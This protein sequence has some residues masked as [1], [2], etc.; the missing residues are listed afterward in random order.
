MKLCVAL[1]QKDYIKNLL[2][3]DSL[4]EY[5]VSFKIGYYSFLI[6]GIKLILLMEEE[7]KDITL[8]FL[9]KLL[10]ESWCK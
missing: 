10:N 8:D 5:P 2:L 9:K 7:R 6:N 3:A 4:K 1:D